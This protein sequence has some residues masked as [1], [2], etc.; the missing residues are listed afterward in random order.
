MVLGSL[1][2]QFGFVLGLSSALPFVTYQYLTTR[3]LPEAL[4]ALPAPSKLPTPEPVEL[5]KEDQA[6]LGGTLGF[7]ASYADKQLAKTGEIDLLLLALR[8]RVLLGTMIAVPLLLWRFGGPFT[9]FAWAGA[10][11]FLSDAWRR[12]STLKT[13]VDMARAR[14]RLELEHE[15]ESGEASSS[16]TEPGAAIGQA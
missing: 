7:L 5:S 4:G 10:G 11:A 3:D 12:Y 6:L 2:G 1:N 14:A 9:L 8:R 13:R 15:R 16:G